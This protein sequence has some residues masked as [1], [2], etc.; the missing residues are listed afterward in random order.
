MD[1]QESQELIGLAGGIRE[2]AELIGIH[3][4]PGWYHRVYAWQRRGI[5]AQVVLDNLAKIVS[6]QRRAGGN[7]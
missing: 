5:P 4:E 2:F 3:G 7:G 1:V 6:L